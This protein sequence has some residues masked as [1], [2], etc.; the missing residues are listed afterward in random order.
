MSEISEHNNIRPEDAVPQYVWG[1]PEPSEDGESPVMIRRKIKNGY[2]WAGSIILWQQLFAFIIMM[3]ITGIMSA[4]LTTQ[5]LAENPDMDMNELTLTITQQV[6]Q[7]DS[8]ILVNA[9]T[10]VAANIISLAIVCG[11]KKQFK[12]KSVFGKSSLAGSSVLI[13]IIG[14]IGIQA[15]SVLI[16]TLVT[17]ITGISGVGNSLNNSL[18][19]KDSFALNIVLFLYMVIAGP[20][21]EEL[22]FRGAALNLLAPVD[23]KFALIASSLL[24][25]LMHCNFNQIFNGFLLGLILGYIA[26]KSG[27]IIPSIIM[28]MLLNLNVFIIGFIFEHKLAETIGI[29]AAAKAELIAFGVEAVI[30]IIA[31]VILLK[32]HG[33]ITEN[34]II[35]PEY[36]YVLEDSE[37]K[38]LTW[39]AF[40]K[41]PSIIISIIFCVFTACTLVTVG[42]GIL[43]K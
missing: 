17:Y 21:L 32:K 15:A 18:G 12:L 11:A 7:S 8:M 38:K 28:H 29:E 20:I 6:M 42:V 10:M 23:R 5:L 1:K 13:A 19:F 31:L 37:E 34:D 40:I 2:N 25:G 16:Q 9:V 4:K 35:I 39:Q 43:N 3:I 30:G 24:F 26:L 41:S 14:A 36:S 27:S 22:L 33:R